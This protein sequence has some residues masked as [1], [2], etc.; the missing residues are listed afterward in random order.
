VDITERMWINKVMSKC[1][2]LYLI[3]LKSVTS[4]L[5]K[6]KMGMCSERKVLEVL[7]ELIAVMYSLMRS[8]F[9]M[10]YR[11]L[12][13]RFWVLTV[14]K[15]TLPKYP[16]VIQHSRIVL[17]LGQEVSYP[18]SNKY[19]ARISLTKFLFWT[20]LFQTILRTNQL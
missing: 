4:I 11:R 13:E 19:R 6:D 7:L 1:R 3:V 12:E 2:K 8:Q 15:L 9:R 17:L 18:T 10:S 14:S 16:L 20:P 5:C